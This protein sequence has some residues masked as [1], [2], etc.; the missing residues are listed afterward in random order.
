M[1]KSDQNC[2]KAVFNR[3]IKFNFISPVDKVRFYPQLIYPPERSSL[4]DQ[5]YSKI[6][7]IVIKRILL[8]GSR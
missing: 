2:I 7:S 8:T 3:L 1:D 4:Q 6:L 5:K